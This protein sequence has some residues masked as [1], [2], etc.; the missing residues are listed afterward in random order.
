VR[1]TVYGAGGVGGY[2]G[3]RLALGG[4]DVHLIARGAH[5]RAL[6]EHG[7]RVRSTLGDFATPV[8]ATDD[9]AEVGACDVVLFCVKSYD[10][11]E[12]ADS[13]APLLQAG[14]GV[15]TLQNGVDNVEKLAAAIGE[16]HVLGG[17]AYIFATV[18]EPGVIAH[19]GAPGSFVFGEL[20]G[21]RSERAE[22]LLAL[23]RDADV[24]ADLVTNIRVRLWEKFVFICA[25]AGVTAT[26]LVPI[27]V[28]RKTPE[29]WDLFQ[30]ILG[31]VAA[32]AAAEGVPL[33]PDAVE[34]LTGWGRTLEPT[35]F[36]SLYDDLARGRRIELEALHGF[37]VRRSRDRGLQAPVSEVIY[38]LLKPHVIQNA[39]R[40]QQE[41]SPE[42]TW[43]SGP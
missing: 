21:A 15:L 33:E 18:V 32:L 9:P 26:A 10:T 31:E 11:E 30:R 2:F 34:Q 37:V 39:D 7:L 5:L 22:R 17:A 36:S 1:I 8:H 20:D 13:L 40:Y 3:G 25:Q 4:A 14:T 38:A 24:R 6:Q 23:C 29:T 42:V 19:T 27:G 16:R 43:A 35:V 41:R 12:A 28:I